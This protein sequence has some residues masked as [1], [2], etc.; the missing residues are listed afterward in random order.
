MPLK[1]DWIKNE[2]DYAKA[3]GRMSHEKLEKL[4]LLSDRIKDVGV[5]PE[6]LIG[7]I[8]LLEHGNWNVNTAEKIHLRWIN[9]KETS[10]NFLSIPD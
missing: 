2:V 4:V 5:D 1:D 10:E 6:D 8:S 9:G 3:M 7:L